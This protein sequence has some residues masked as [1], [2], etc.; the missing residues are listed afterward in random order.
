LA[1]LVTHIPNKGEQMVRYYGYYSN[2]SRKIL[3]HLGAFMSGFNAGVGQL[4]WPHS[5]LWGQGS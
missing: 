5:M 2:N 1:Q 3:N 4:P